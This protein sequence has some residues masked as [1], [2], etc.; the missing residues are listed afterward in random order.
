[1]VLKNRWRVDPPEINLRIR[2]S[3]R[4][5]ATKKRKRKKKKKKKNKR[6]KRNT[7]ISLSLFVLRRDIKWQRGNVAAPEAADD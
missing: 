1:M 7:N 5:A 4:S 6:R 2:S 3:R